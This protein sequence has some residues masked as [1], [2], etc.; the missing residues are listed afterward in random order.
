[1]SAGVNTDGISDDV[2]E[3][4]MERPSSALCEPWTVE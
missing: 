4:S 1:V 2:L 3:T